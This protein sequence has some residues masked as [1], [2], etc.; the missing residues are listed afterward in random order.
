MAS[1]LT[2]FIVVLIV[3]GTLVAGLIVGAQRDD[4]T[5]NQSILRASSGSMIGMPSR[6]G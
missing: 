3:A 6:I 1:R 4:E 5:R 2:T